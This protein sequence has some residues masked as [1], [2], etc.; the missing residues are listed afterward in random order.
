MWLKKW[1]KKY[2]AKIK[3][4]RKNAQEMYLQNGMF[5]TPLA[6][7][8]YIYHGKII[9]GVREYL[10]AQDLKVDRLNL[11]LCISDRFSDD[12]DS[13]KAHS[14][15]SIL[16]EKIGDE[17]VANIFIGEELILED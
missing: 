15:S 1:L 10:E 3:N 17:I 5:F 4:N 7:N 11:V 6:D 12:P 16:V 8:T 13:C 14:D 2:L 9:E